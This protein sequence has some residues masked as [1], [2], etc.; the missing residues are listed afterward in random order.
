MNYSI[1]FNK[2][3]LS[4]LL[5]IVVSS[6][7]IS[8]QKIADIG[9]ATDYCRSHEL[10]AI[11]GIWEFPDDETKVLIKSDGFTDRQYDIILLSSADTR[12]K[13]GEC[14]GK[15]EKSADSG[16]YKLAL[17]AARKDGILSDSRSCVAEF[18]PQK[19]IILIKPRKISLSILRRSASSFLP[20]FWR[21]ISV[22]TENPLNDL[23]R[24]LIRIFPRE[25]P[26]NPFYL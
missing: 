10:T 7:F 17:Y 24:G 20:K 25:N 3:Q 6:T 8:A 14:I 15:L 11:E 18:N 9:A 22:S 23:H 19:E 1:I 5:W 13:P 21:L 16:K 2:R 4:I 12:I 26:E